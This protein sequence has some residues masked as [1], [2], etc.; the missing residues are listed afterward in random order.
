MAEVNP[1]KIPEI[2]HKSGR[3]VLFAPACLSPETVPCKVM[4]GK[5]QAC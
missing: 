4:Y 2:I 1:R 3:R 5:I